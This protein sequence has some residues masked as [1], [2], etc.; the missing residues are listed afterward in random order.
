MGWKEYAA[1]TLYQGYSNYETWSIALWIQ[2]DRRLY[3]EASNAVNY[4]DFLHRLGKLFWT[5]S[6]TPDGV[7]W[8]AEPINMFQLD[9][10]IVYIKEV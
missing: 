7:S 3:N 10:L 9:Q 6:T 5:S 8:L 2:N 1:S 4:M